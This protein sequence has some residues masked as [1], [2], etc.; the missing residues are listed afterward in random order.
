MLN[1]CSGSRKKE[2]G[3]AWLTEQHTRVL[4]VIRE[5]IREFGYPPSVRELG[6]KLASSR[7]LPCTRTSGISSCKGYLKRTAQKS[8]AFNII[9]SFEVS[10][11]AR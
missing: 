10:E 3:P 1:F 6:E 9:D 2:E 11:P 5:S 7:P 4:E 8:R